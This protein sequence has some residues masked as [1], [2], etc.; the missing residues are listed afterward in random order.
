MNNPE[1]QNV[2]VSKSTEGSPEAKKGKCMMC[3]FV[4]VFSLI[5]FFLVLILTVVLTLDQ[6]EEVLPQATPSVTL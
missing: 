4:L 3:K 6:P 1:L 5:A 2:N